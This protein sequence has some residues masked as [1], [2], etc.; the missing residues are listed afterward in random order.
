MGPRTADEIRACYNDQTLLTTVLPD[1]SHMFERHVGKSVKSMLDRCI[2]KEHRRSE[3]TRLGLPNPDINAT[4]SS[5]ADIDSA[6][7]L[8]EETITLKADDI[9]RWLASPAVQ[10]HCWNCR[11][12]PTLEEEHPLRKHFSYELDADAYTDFPD[13]TFGGKG[14]MAKHDAHNNPKFVVVETHAVDVTLT[15]TADGSFIVS[16][17]YPALSAQFAST[18]TTDADLTRIVQNTF[19]WSRG[20]NDYRRK[21]YVACSHDKNPK[22]PRSLDTNGPELPTRADAPAASDDFE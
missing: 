21:L 22:L 10:E 13:I 1:E 3:R 15:A 5:F 11:F 7:M 17:A 16:N 12:D 2:G 6:R 4:T 14:V 18:H 19:A 8:V 9:A 20:D